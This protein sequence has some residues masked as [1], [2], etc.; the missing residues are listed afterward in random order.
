[1]GLKTKDEQNEEKRSENKEANNDDLFSFS[2]HRQIKARDQEQ[3]KQM[4]NK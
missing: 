1:V 2:H 3:T 4:S